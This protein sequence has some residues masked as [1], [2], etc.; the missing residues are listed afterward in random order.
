MTARKPKKS[1]TLEIRLSH[2]AKQAFM[3]NAATEGRSASAIIRDFVAQYPASECRQGHGRYRFAGMALA[4]AAA[5]A[6]LLSTTSAGPAQNPAHAGH[7]DAN[8]GMLIKLA[9]RKPID[10]QVYAN[11]RAQLRGLK[12]GLDRA[13]PPKGSVR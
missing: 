9:D 3:S 2:E 5:P 13:A 12:D 7:G 11:L 1:E 8:A 10:A 6:L 4:A